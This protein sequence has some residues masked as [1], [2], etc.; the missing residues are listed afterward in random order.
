MQQTILTKALSASSSNTLGSFSSAA[1]TLYTSGANFT[2]GTA[3]GAVATPLDTQRRIALW[4]TAA[5]QSSLLVTLTGLNDNG[6][7]VKESIIGSTAASTI[8]RT[9]VQD[10]ATVT[11]VSFSSAPLEGA[12]HIAT[13]TKG[14]TPWILADTWR[15][16]FSLGAVITLS[17]TVNSMAANFEITTEDITQSYVPGPTK[18]ISTSPSVTVPWYPT[19]VISQVAGSTFLSTAIDAATLG[20]FTA[21]FA[22]WRVTLTSS[23]STAGAAG[24]EVLQAG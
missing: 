10:F 17:S 12:L 15:D 11:S 8:T 7:I 2:V 1:T 9:T 3:S 5:D 16:P 6:D 21:P 13:N 22:A 23:S 24:I 14:G 20:V 4:S 19:P 18:V